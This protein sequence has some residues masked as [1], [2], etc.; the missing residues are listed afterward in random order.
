VD[1]DGVPGDSI[2]GGSIAGGGV[3]GGGIVGGGVPGGSIAGG[4]V[5]GGD[6]P[7]SGI[8]GPGEPDTLPAEDLRPDE[9]SGGAADPAAWEPAGFGEG[10]AGVP[11]WEGGFPGGHPA[12]PVTESYFDGPPGQFG[13]PAPGRRGAPAA[14]GA[15]AAAPPGH[16]AGPGRANGFA[17]A[18]LVLGLL[19]VTVL[20]A[21]LSIV[22]G[23]VALRQIRRRWQRG[24]GMAIAGIVF[25]V[26]WLAAIGALVGINV[27]GSGGKT[28]SAG[29]PSASAPAG[30]S[31]SAAPGGRSV[32]VFALR[33]GECFQNPPASQT[34]LGVTY[35]TVVG[36]TTPHNAQAFVQFNAAGTGYPGASALKV[37]ADR[38]CHARIR[39]NVQTSKIKSTMS[40]H[41]LYPLQSSWSTGH[42]TITCL[43]VNSKPTLTSSLLR[44]H[45]KG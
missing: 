6:I 13:A 31:S 30:R 40:L 22:F 28:P 12:G 7:G 34:V 2:A 24:R 16:R 45:P 3:P 38:G 36:C 17:I 11:P 1:D 29:R 18:S 35:V 4:G 32:N 44:A 33:P 37:Q 9:F 20:G 26:L 21:V 19:G 25:S 14:P 39:A 43:I 42:R 15:G 10:P 5:P 23:I 41:Y 8:A 27:G